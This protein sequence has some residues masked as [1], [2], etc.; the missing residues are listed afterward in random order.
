MKKTAVLLCALL[1]GLLL[2]ACG[3]KA[4]TGE[5]TFLLYY[6]AENLA[7][8]SGEDAIVVRETVIA[9]AQ[10]LDTEQL[11]LRL[12]TALLHTPEDPTVHTPFPNGTQ[13]LALEKVGKLLYVDFSRHYARNTGI[14]LALADYCVTL[15]LTQL[16]AVNMVSITAGGRTLP[17]R[18]NRVLTAA[19]PLL[20]RTEETLRPVSVLLYFADGNGALRAERHTLRLYEGK[21]RASALLEAL[22]AGPVSDELERCVPADLGILS[23]RAEKGTCF[24]NLAAGTELS[25]RETDALVSS[26]CSLSNVQ[27]VQLA[28][29]GEVLPMMGSVDVSRPLEPMRE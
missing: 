19:E 6:P 17:N 14:D 27:R 29:G 23:V 20:S 21:S 12:L 7:A 28:F 15:T 4:E 10:Q 25:A 5:N 22:L 8:V 16:E 9:D 3:E 2:F 18:E 1:L 24:L 11:A 13:L 26:L